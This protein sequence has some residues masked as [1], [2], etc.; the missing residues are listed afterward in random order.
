MLTALSLYSCLP[1]CYG[2]FSQSTVSGYMAIAYTGNFP[3]GTPSDSSE[4][5][6]PTP[7]QP[8]YTHGGTHYP[9]SANRFTIIRQPTAQQ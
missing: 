4:G 8:S 3:L 1:L 5:D 7:P 6:S 2:N 9:P